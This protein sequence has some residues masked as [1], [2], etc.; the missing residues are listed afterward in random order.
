MKV[1]TWLLLVLV[2]SLPPPPPQPASARI[3]A[4]APSVMAVFISSSLAVPAEY[5]QKPLV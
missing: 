5:G 3:A 2:L 4:S 1:P